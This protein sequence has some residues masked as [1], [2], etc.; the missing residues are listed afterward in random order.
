MR[1][2]KRVGHETE[3]QCAGSYWI[4][5]YIR[6]VVICWPKLQTQRRTYEEGAQGAIRSMH[7]YVEL[8]TTM[9]VS[10]SQT[11]SVALHFSQVDIAQRATT[12][13]IEHISNLHCLAVDP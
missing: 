7:D 1:Y 11:K 4:G 9:D 12:Q 8:R 13:G 3:M 5:G 10:Q 2:V 6:V